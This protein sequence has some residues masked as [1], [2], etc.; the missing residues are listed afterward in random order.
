MYGLSVVSGQL[1]V[2]KKQ[3]T[4][5]NGRRT[6]LLSSL[7]PALSFCFGVER[8]LNDAL[9]LCGHG[10]IVADKAFDHASLAIKDECL[11][12]SVIIGQ[13]CCCHLGVWK[14]ERILNLELLDIRGYFIAILRAADV[15]A[16]DVQ[17][18]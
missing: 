11:W 10:V 18:L 13:I 6:V 15:E 14:A 5:D 9:Q 1:S 7:I 4:T 16:D 8:R 3:R 2:V 12:N 17:S